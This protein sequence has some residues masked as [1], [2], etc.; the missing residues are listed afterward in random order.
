MQQLTDNSNGSGLKAGLVHGRWEPRSSS[1]QD[2]SHRS[3]VTP[4]RA[5]RHTS[6]GGTPV[7]TKMPHTWHETKKVPGGS[8][9]GK[10][11]FF[12]WSLGSGH[13][14]RTLALWK[15]NLQIPFLFAIFKYLFSNSNSRSKVTISLI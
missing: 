8:A 1:L 9:G 13:S 10:G 11:S 14:S 12:P 7:S 15:T 3:T 4:S 2:E 6:E 5:Q